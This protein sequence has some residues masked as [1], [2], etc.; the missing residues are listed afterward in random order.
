MSTLLLASY[1]HPNDLPVRLKTCQ[2][3]NSQEL[4]VLSRAGFLRTIWIYLVSVIINFWGHFLWW[5]RPSPPLH[6]TAFT[7]FFIFAK[8]SPL[9]DATILCS[10]SVSNFLHS[11]SPHQPVHSSRWLLLQHMCSV[12]VHACHFPGSGFTTSLFSSLRSLINVFNICPTHSSA[13][14][15]NLQLSVCWIDAEL[16]SS[17]GKGR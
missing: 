6:F 11:D 5:S 12:L 1:S 3:Y 8:S 4:A 10:L 16:L 17:E 15:Q 2:L 9:H 14:F 7:H 13:S